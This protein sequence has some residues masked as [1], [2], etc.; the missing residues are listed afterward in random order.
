MELE[1][2]SAVFR[3]LADGK[4]DA[5]QQ[6]RSRLAPVDRVERTIR[7]RTGREVHQ[8]S[9][10]REHSKG[11]DV[12]GLLPDAGRGL[13]A[14]G[15]T[16]NR[17]R[18]REVSRPAAQVDGRSA[19]STS[20][21]R[22]R[23]FARCV[24]PTWGC[25][26]VTHGPKA[27]GPAR[28]ASERTIVASVSATAWPSRSKSSIAFAGSTAL[29]SS[30]SRRRAAPGDCSEALVKDV[31]AVAVEGENGRSTSV[32]PPGRSV[33]KG[34]LLCVVDS[35]QQVLLLSGRF[36]GSLPESEMRKSGRTPFVNE[37]A[38]RNPSRRRRRQRRHRGGAG[39]CAG[40]VGGSHLNPWLER[41]RPAT[42]NQ[43]RHSL[44]VVG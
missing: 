25:R 2:V 34:N 17:R 7:G 33:P 40:G 44:P 39:S 14:R 20:W 30:S 36:I 21:R 28:A 43:F 19:E 10:A 35:H 8:Q 42:R 6:A 9:R 38:W 24:A 18:R 26:R 16:P 29:E 13:L 5:G 31:G 15:A 27:T 23:R 22:K 37:S 1:S 4:E 32:E 11:R 3:A 12:L 41:D